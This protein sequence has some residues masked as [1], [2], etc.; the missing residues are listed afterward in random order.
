MADGNLDGEVNQPDLA[1]W[2]ANYGIVLP[3]AAMH[4][5]EPTAMLLTCVAVLMLPRRLRV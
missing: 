1:I 3:L 5:P 4:V 2:E